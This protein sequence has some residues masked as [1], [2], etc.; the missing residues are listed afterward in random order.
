MANL[1]RLYKTEAIILKHLPLG[2]ADYIITLYTPQLGKLSAVVKGARKVKSK[3]GGHLEPLMHTSFL[4]VRGRNLHSVSQ[5]QTIE[6]FR[7]IREDLNKLSL[8]TYMA[9]LVDAVTPDEQPNY[10]LFR[11]LET[12]LGYLAKGAPN[13]LTTFFQ[14]DLLDKIG[15][16]PELYRCVE[17]EA[18]IE[19]GNHRFAP[20]RGGTICK[21]CQP[22]LS[23]ILP[24]S[25]NC[26][27]A[28]RFL[29]NEGYSAV[30][31][32]NLQDDMILELNAITH[33]L[34]TDLLDR[35]IK[36][37]KILDQITAFLTTHAHPTGH[38]STI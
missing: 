24:I 1:Q 11:L 7:A 3:V 23:R 14:L 13:S 26:I 15:F 29:Q 25:I 36:A 34:V 2:E 18:T 38:E 22:N 5:A 37:F 31:R 4:L 21:S 8:A 27:K 32:L 19:P 6:P 35:D 17:C 28:L 16:K 12:C 10:Q 20:G 33:W 9:A 30:A